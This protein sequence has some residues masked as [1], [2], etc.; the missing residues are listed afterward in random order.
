MCA[1]SLRIF[2]IPWFASSEGRE[3]PFIDRGAK[4]IARGN[5][6]GS[7]ISLRSEFMAGDSMVVQDLGDRD[8]HGDGYAMRG[9]RTVL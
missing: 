9:K 5:V 3:S 4:S 7:G 1:V 2:S 8:R 6:F